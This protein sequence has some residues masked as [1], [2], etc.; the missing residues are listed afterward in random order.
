LPHPG[1]PAAEPPH[2]L[3]TFVGRAEQLSALRALLARD[4]IRLLTLTGPGGVGKT[5]LA[6]ELARRADVPGE[7]WFVSLATVRDA[8]LVA[9]TITRALELPEPLGHP[10]EDTLV[11]ALADR[12]GVLILD[13]FEQIAES[14]PLVARITAECPRVKVLVTSRAPLRLTGEFI[15]TVPPLSLPASGATRASETREADAVR[16][17][18]ERASE[19]S[20]EFAPAASDLPVIADIC[21]RLN[22]LPLAIELAAARVSILSLPDLL[23]RLGQRLTLLTRG[24]VDTPERHRT[25]RNAIAWSYDLLSP[26]EQRLFRALAVFDGG[27][28]LSAVERIASDAPSVAT[29]AQMT[30]LA[31]DALAMLVDHHLIDR[32]EAVTETAEP[33]YEMLETIREFALERLEEHGEE[34]AVRDAHVALCLALAAEG[35]THLIHEVEPAWLDRLEEEHP[36]FRGALEWSLREG[37]TP[38]ARE[39]GVELAGTLWL[40]W[41]YHSHLTEGRAWLERALAVGDVATP[42]AR[43]RALVGLGTM[44]HFQGEEQRARAMLLHGLE[45]LRDLGDTSG[46]AYA[47]TGIGNLAE[48]TGLYEEAT[49]AFTEANALF[50]ALDDRVNVAVTRYHL[51][52]VAVGKGDLALATS[53]LEDALALGKREGDPWS[54]AAALSY[55]G[56]VQVA[57][58]D[59][60]DAA[61]AL[62]EALALYRQIGTTERIVEVLRRIAVLAAAQREPET[63]LRLFAAADAHGARIGTVQALPEREMYARAAAA[64]GRGLPAARQA[65]ARSAGDALTLDDAIA[66]AERLLAATHRRQPI[67]A[68]PLPGVAPLS[69]REMQVLRLIVEGKSDAEIAVALSISRRTAT[70][71]AGHIYAKLNVTSRSAAVAFAVRNGLV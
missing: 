21:R 26:V 70:T 24:Q 69:E 1:G 15:F 61:D 34:E 53:Q 33:R 41:Y 47:L 2:I 29:A 62:A 37:A 51:G 55:L 22:G 30:G 49:Q 20:S 31:V 25:L 59:L 17:F 45:L 28:S 68:E 71:H 16:L 56:L 12:V 44:L 3:S 40:F 18:I 6:I 60:H 65:A 54:T 42:A 9:G 39:T 64:A 63:A 67:H 4:D 27:V 38:E 52:V 36:N 57:R 48:D 10:V 5:R 58:D 46:M 7:L 23:D 14:A 13:N 11:A 35:E 66:D 19:V 50:A 32:V 8:A 43:A